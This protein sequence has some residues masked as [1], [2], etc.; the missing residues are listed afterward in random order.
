MVHVVSEVIMRENV[1][2]IPEEIVGEGTQV[3]REIEIPGGT[4]NTNI[5]TGQ[6][7]GQRIEK[8]GTNA[9]THTGHTGQTG[10]TDTVTRTGDINMRTG[11]RS[12]RENVL[13]LQKH[14]IRAVRHRQ[15][16]IAA[17]HVRVQVHRHD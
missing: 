7:R 12:Q 1:S 6:R 4:T 10:Q 8:I 3:E 16:Q 17:A 2:A 9:L 11:T 15:G 14:Q 13:L 5:L